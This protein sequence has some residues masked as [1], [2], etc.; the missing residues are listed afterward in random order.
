MTQLLVL[1]AVSAALDLLLLTPV[2]WRMRL[3]IAFA[4]VA[5]LS[6]ATGGLLA[7]E[8][9]LASILIFIL[10][11]YRL[12]NL[13]RMARAQ[14]EEAYLRRV[15]RKTAVWLAGLQAGVVGASVLVWNYLHLT[16]DVW[17]TVVAFAQFVVAAFLFWSMGQSLRKTKVLQNEAALSDRQLPSVTVAI[18][19]RNEDD[20]LEACLQTVLASD[21][22]KL[23]VIVLDDCSHDRT[24]EIVRQ[25]AHDGVR[26]IPG[27]EPSDN[28][29]AKN[30]AYDKLAEAASGEII[31]FCGVDVR[32]GGRSIRQLVTA[33]VRKDKTMASVLPLNTEMQRPPFVQTM[34]Y[35]WELIPPRRLF[36]RPA[37]MSS[38]WLIRR[39]ELERAGG[40]DAVSRSITPEAYFA[41]R[42][43]EH[44]GYSFV[45]SDVDLD[46]TSVKAAE[47]QMATAVRTRYPQLHRRPE[48]VAVVSAIE[49]VFLFGPLV[50]AVLNIWLR[51]GWLLEIFAVGAFLLQVVMYSLLEVIIFTRRQVL[52]VVAFPLAVLGDIAML[53]YSMWKYEF[54]EVS[55]KGRNVCLPVMRVIPRL[56]KI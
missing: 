56:P 52:A 21:Y 32:F 35:G 1:L 48:L 53:N 33:L 3:P 31:L 46:I 49:L 4:S 42:A 17:L 9:G 26:F 13:L 15:T 6:M 55:W 34:R 2:G 29:L 45:R 10:S 28:W 41:K 27:Q 37:V 44:D 8:F 24:P 50:L 40:F 5:L 54:S 20:Q 30:Q 36:N 7:L 47:E 39:E 14:V 22:P 18:P 12:F 11:F 43:T 16:Q 19:A 51:M 25:Y 23:E 38:C